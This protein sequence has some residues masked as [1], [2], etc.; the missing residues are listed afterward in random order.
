MQDTELRSARDHW[1]DIAK[2]I[3]ILLVVYG[4]VARG[5]FNADLGMDAG[6]FR[7]IDDLIYDF[8][9]PLF[10][11]LSGLYL[12]SSLQKYGAGGLIRS[13]LDTLLYPYLVW[14]LL[15]GSVEVFLSRYTTSQTNMAEV[16]RLFWQPRAQFWF[17]YVLFIVFVVAVLL[18]QRHPT[19]LKAGLL[20]ALAA[21]WVQNQW[22][23]LF[24]LDFVASFM[25]FFLAGTLF[26]QYRSIFRQHAL[27]VL[28]ISGFSFSTL[29]WI[30][31][32]QLGLHHDSNHWLKLPLS[33]SGILLVISVSML[34]ERRQANQP[35]QAGLRG[36]LTQA[37]LLCGSYSMPIYLM[38]ILSGSGIR[39]VLKKVFHLQSAPL[40]LLLGC[41]FAVLLPLLFYRLRERQG[42]QWIGL[43][44]T[45]PR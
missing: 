3:G 17:L 22:Q 25:L 19:R 28:L 9:M 43:L 14:S 23:L 18:L 13:K 1:T 16:L 39:I 37:L 4:H 8:H 31:H 26:Q 21:W 33:L 41:L 34:L 32:S 24:P 36:H 45:A 7:L 5:V 20:L 2:G 38:H 35:G 10:F 15:Q 44:F 30:Y 11:W 12:L 27:S 40:H 42:F 6:W 29:A